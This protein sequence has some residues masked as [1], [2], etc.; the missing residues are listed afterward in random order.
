MTLV[1]DDH[2]EK[3]GIIAIVVRLEDL[4]GIL[5]IDSARECLID[6]E[7]YI[8]IRWDF[9][10]SS[11]DLASIDLDDIFL[12]WVECIHRLIDEDIAIR[13]DEDTRSAN[14]DSFFRPTS[15]KKFIGNLECYDG[16]PC[17]CGECQENSVFF[18][19][20]GF[21]DFVDGYLL[22]ISWSFVGYIVRFSHKN[23][24]H[25]IL[26]REY[27]SI[28]LIWMW[29]LFYEVSF[30]EFEIEFIDLTS[31]G[32]VDKP[33][34]QDLSIFFYLFESL[35]GIEIIFF[36]FYDG[37][38]YAID[39]QDIVS[40]FLLSRLASDE[41]ASEGEVVFTD[42]TRIDPAILLEFWVNI[43]GTSIGFRI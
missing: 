35:S 7:E 32:R 1:D 17:S 38:I 27:A 26:L 22:I 8:C 33:D 37:E 28:Q 23:F 16:L 13:E 29:I 10:M 43:F 39:P 41:L 20:E 24:S 11:L 9:S 30:P 2:I 40:E 12:E 19:S 14:P 36:G 3:I 42:H 18:I 5:F 4:I 6:R 21:H 34:I 25:I 15:I 31:I